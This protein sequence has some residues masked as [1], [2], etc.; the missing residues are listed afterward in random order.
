MLSRFRLPRGIVANAESRLQLKATEIENFLKRK[1][2]R[3]EKTSIQM[4]KDYAEEQFD[5]I[6]YR[7]KKE[8]DSGEVAMEQYELSV[9]VLEEMPIRS[10][11][12]S[13]LPPLRSDLSVDIR[14]TL[15]TIDQAMIS[16]SDYIIVYGI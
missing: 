4:W 8:I 15:D 10:F 11:S 7:V 14:D 3:K 9:S 13:L 6:A 16:V 1:R 12:T 2:K 5:N